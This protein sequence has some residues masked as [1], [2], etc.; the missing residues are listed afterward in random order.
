[1][2]L[3][4]V[5]VVLHM[6]IDI[7]SPYIPPLHTHTHAHTHTHSLS[8]STHV[9]S[10][11]FSPPPHT[12]SHKDVEGLMADERK[13]AKST[14]E[15]L[16]SRLESLAYRINDLEYVKQEQEGTIRVQQQEQS[17]ASSQIQVRGGYM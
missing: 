4:F 17:T 7:T 1:M 11:S 14:I 12:Q 10:H 6:H 13:N 16:Q 3:R 15:G 5:S 8:L 9:S 2:Y